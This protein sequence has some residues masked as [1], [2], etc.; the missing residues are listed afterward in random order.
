MID[1]RVRGWLINKENNVN[2]GQFDVDASTDE[3]N[4][5]TN[6]LTCKHAA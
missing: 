2:V 6:A 3:E 5:C 4:L 1:S